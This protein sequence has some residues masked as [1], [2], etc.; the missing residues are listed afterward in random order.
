M[1]TYIP[2]FMIVILFAGALVLAGCN[3][4]EDAPGSIL[5]YLE[6]LAA[7]D[8][9]TLSSLSCADWEAQAR[10]ELEAFSAVT[11]A[12]EDAACSESGEDGDYTLVSC[13][14]KIIANYGN[15]VLEIELGD[16]TYLAAFEAGEWR[17]CGYR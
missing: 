13:T 11:I 15:E 9:D 5:A 1:R 17:M 12:L 16:R 7:R 8:A 10:T 4:Q 6:A 14:G 2:T 3:P